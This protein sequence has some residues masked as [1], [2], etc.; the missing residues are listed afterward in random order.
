MIRQSINLSRGILIMICFL[1][2]NNVSATN[3]YFDAHHG[4]DENVGTSL[5]NPFQSLDKIQS[6]KLLPG[7]TILLRAG[8]TFFGSVILKDLKGSSLD[9]I[10]ITSYFWSKSNEENRA[11]I[12]AKGYLNGILI[13]DCSHIIIENL[14]IGA[15]GG[16]VKALVQKAPL[17]RCGVLVKS[18]HA[19]VSEGIRLS[20]L[21]VKDV[22]FEEKGHLRGKDEVRTANGT[23]NYGW[24]IRFINQVEGADLKDIKVENCVITNVAHTGIKFTG[25][26]HNIQNVRVYNNRVLK[27]GGPGIQMSGITNGHIKG[28]YVSHSGSDDDSRK[29]G[30]GSGLWTWGSDDV[31]IENNYFLHANGP[32]D[33]AGCHIDFNCNHVV[34]QYN[35]SAH[36]AGG[37]CEILGNNH[38]CAYRYN[39]SINDGHREK[40]KEGAFQEGKTYWL[41]GYVGRQKKRH[42]PYNSYFYNNTIYSNADILSKVAVTKT[43]EGVLIAN[44]IFCIEGPTKAVLGDQYNP[45]IGGFGDIPN[46][47][48]ENNLFLAETIWP[49]EVLIQPG[50]ILSGD[51]QFLE[52]GGVNPMD[53]IPTNINLIKDKGI[54]IP[55]ISNDLLGLKIGLKVSKDILG[56]PIR[57]L[58]DLGAIEVE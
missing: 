52:K 27:T 14:L 11:A 30:R 3:Y 2:T 13:Q 25:R 54:E 57:R 28:N 41:S 8:Q 51:P 50:G 38:N 46:V 42:G 16:G 22:F 15:D 7:D 26:D 29:W 45:D 37:F 1:L 47:F 58:P 48:F 40:G 33:S 21:V 9:P 20:N 44:N 49:K 53:Y 10:V 39:I 32:A 12:D 18:S 31:L 36:N 6:L 34:V 5:L 17:M 23:Q 19:G 35:L 56:N 4:K 24:G 55:H 43:A